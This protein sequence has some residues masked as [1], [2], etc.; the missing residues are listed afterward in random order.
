MFDQLM[1]KIHAQTEESHGIF[2]TVGLVLPWCRILFLLVNFCTCGASVT[3]LLHF[4]A[5]VNDC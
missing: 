1:L 2:D 5:T 4:C 3:G